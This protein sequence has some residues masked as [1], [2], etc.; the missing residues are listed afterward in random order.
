[1]GWFWGE[2]DKT[3]NKGTNDALYNLDPSLR[4]FLA[5]EA[6]A[7]YESSDPPDE[8][9]SLP[10]AR[11]LSPDASSLE[12]DKPK[13][14][15]RSLYQDGRYADLWK[16]YRPQAEVEALGKSDQEKVNDVLDDFKSRR[17][18]IGRISME[19]CA[20]EQMAVSDCFM[21]GGWSAKT[22]MCKMENREFNR[23]YMMQAKFLKA[24]GYLTNADRA[25]EVDEQI[26][27]HADTLYHRMLDQEKAVEEAKAEGRPVPTFPPLFEKPKM[28]IEISQLRPNLQ[29]EVKKQLDKA[30][31]PDKGLAEVAVNAEL[32]AAAETARKLEDINREQ[33]VERRKRKE[34][35]RETVADK[36][37]YSWRAK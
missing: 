17:A 14:P 16:S 8:P 3:P 33:E 35:G 20:L 21:K 12:D 27:M 24:L 25:P 32:S 2:S 7:K 36:V 18:E 4:D 5:K 9:R 11:T 23:C 31:G 13:V 26:Q 30:E 6:P 10:R 28:M 15:S 19:N 34:Q 1:M 37:Y 22:T 29:A